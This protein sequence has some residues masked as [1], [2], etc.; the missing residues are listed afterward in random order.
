[1]ALLP[2]NRFPINS[3][4]AFMRPLITLILL[5]LILPI[6]AARR[7][8]D[9]LYISAVLTREQRGR[10]SSTRTT[11]TIIVEGNKIVYDRIYSGFRG[12]YSEPVHRE[13][14]ITGADAQRLERVIKEHGL[15]VSDKL[16]YPR[17]IGG[18]W[19]FRITL[20]LRSGGQKS[21]IEIAGPTSAVK[22]REEKLYKNSSTLLK[23]IFSIINAQ[24]TEIP[25]EDDLIDKTH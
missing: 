21:L 7:A 24:D 18:F 8:A 6:F 9:D 19:H 4:Q 20:N 2:A 17:R 5:I 22:I 25:R 3:L 10:D 15:L 13:Y 16:D 14:R 11:T 23:E 1:M 12:S